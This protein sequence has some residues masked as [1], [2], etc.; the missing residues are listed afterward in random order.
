[1]NLMQARISNPDDK[2]FKWLAFLAIALFALFKLPELLLPYFWDELGV[3]SR[4]AL[5][6]A[7]N[8]LR[9]L[10]GS[11]PPELSRGHPLV[12]QFVQALGYVCFGKSVMVGHAIP[13]GI[14]VVLLG[15]VYHQVAVICNRL[16]ALCTVLLLMAQPVFIA[17]SVMVLPEMLLS[18]LCFLSLTS[19]YL[20][21]FV[22]F[23][24]YSSLALLVKESAIIIPV[25]VF[26][27][28]FWQDVVN[29]QQK[30]YMAARPLA[31]TFVPLLVFAGFLLLQKVQNGWFFFPEH[32]GYVSFSLERILKHNQGYQKFLFFEQGRY[33][34][35]KV[36][37]AGAAFWFLK[38]RF[39]PG[40]FTWL[41]IILVITFIAFGSLNFYMNRYMLPVFPFLA[42]LVVVSLYAVSRRAVWVLP[43]TLMLSG[44]CLRDLDPGYFNYD[45]DM[46]Y[47]HHLHVQQ[48]VL[49]RLCEMDN[50]TTTIKADFPMY[51]AISEPEHT[52]F[53]MC[54][55]SPSRLQPG[56]KLHLMTT[57]MGVFPQENENVKLVY[58]VKEGYAEGRIYETTKPGN[59]GP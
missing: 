10:P 14:T 30:G 26:A 40:G 54:D 22:M 9:L 36:L 27:F 53:K 41:S 18:L 55:I 23:A 47:K 12:F 29:R 21:R 39:Q 20:R 48:Q 33:W 17:Q 3:Y 37:I 16:V 57:G 52:G 25:V 4:A 45:C 24:V 8:G 13:L 32:I 6:L 49:N 43:V 59:E 38:K 42:F 51:F 46:G 56:G 2:V 34:W 44:L 28:G 1:M 7:Q 31:L 11:I 19:Y 35:V 58:S 50:D 15:A 5:Y